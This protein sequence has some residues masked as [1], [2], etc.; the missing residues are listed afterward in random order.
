[1]KLYN[2]FNGVNDLFDLYLTYTEQVNDDDLLKRDLDEIKRKSE[3][4]AEFIQQNFYSILFNKETG[5]VICNG[6]K[7]SEGMI[8]KT[9]N[10]IEP[11]F[12]YKP[13]E[14][15]GMNIAQLMPRLFA[16]EHKAFMSNYFEIGEKKVIDNKD[17]K[18]F[19][20]D[21]DNSLM[22]LKI[23]VKLFPI[24][25]ENVYFVG[26]IIKE[27]I[28]DVIFIDSSF[29]IQGMSA[30]LMNVLNIDNKQLFMDNDIPFYLI[31]KK[32]VNFYKIFLHS[33]RK[34]AKGKR[35]I[36]S[37]IQSTSEISS[38]SLNEGSG[39]G[40]KKRGSV[41]DEIQNDSYEVYEED[42]NQKEELRKENTDDSNEN[43]EINENIE[44]EYEIKIPHYI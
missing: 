33:K 8:E 11:I 36:T 22:V 7:G 32:F 39:S 13:E 19:G 16:K 3:N 4:S 31:C 18:S 6:D 23:C 1:M 37:Q 26:M 34:S 44:L 30:K 21:K 9:N 40:G 15:K 17:I 14:L 12:K 24:L 41:I 43:I 35:N 2:I 29:D 42:S 25:N 5:I 10:E 20:K 27:N 28:D 38:L